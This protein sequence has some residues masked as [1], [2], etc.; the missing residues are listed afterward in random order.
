MYGIWTSGGRSEEMEDWVRVFDGGAAGKEPWLG[1]GSSW[2]MRVGLVFFFA[3]LS[4][5]WDGEGGKGKLENSVR[6]GFDPLVPY[7]EKRIFLAFL[8]VWREQG[9]SPTTSR[10]YCLLFRIWKGRLCAPGALVHANSCPLEEIT[11][12]IRT[13]IVKLICWGWPLFI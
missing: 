13:Y 5:N 11:L 12:Y 7:K 6:D 8:D 10:V 9:G 1:F 2:L 4:R 3:R